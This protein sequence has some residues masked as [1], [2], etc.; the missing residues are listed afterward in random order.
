MITGM[1][2]EEWYHW[3]NHSGQLAD[4]SAPAHAAFG[5]WLRKRYGDALVRLARSPNFDFMLVTSSYGHRQ[6]GR[7]A[8]YL[9]SPALSLALRGKLWYHDNDVVSSNYP[10]PTLRASR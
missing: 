9:R 2:T 4:Y 1:M 3:G 6:L 10:E 8:D 7:G 5:S